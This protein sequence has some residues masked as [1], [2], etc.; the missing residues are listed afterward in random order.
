MRTYV[1]TYIH[2]YIHN[3][4]RGSVQWYKQHG[5]RVVPHTCLCDAAVLGFEVVVVGSDGFALFFRSSSPTLRRR[6]QGGLRR[7]HASLSLTAIVMNIR[8]DTSHSHIPLRKVMQD[9]IVTLRDFQTGVM[10][11]DVFCS[12][13]SH[14]RSARVPDVA[15]RHVP[16]IHKVQRTDEDHPASCWICVCFPCSLVLVRF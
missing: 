15:Q 4:Q 8:D 6:R 10:M 12:H 3:T 14:L 7:F 16:M 5:T 1:R 2:T 9:A 11:D 13:S